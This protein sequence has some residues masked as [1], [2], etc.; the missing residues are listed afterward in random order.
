MAQLLFEAR[1][2]IV[3]QLQTII[4]NPRAFFSVLPPTTN[5]SQSTL[6]NYILTTMLPH[7]HK[8]YVLLDSCLPTLCTTLNW[9]LRIASLQL[10]S[11]LL[12]LILS[13]SKNAGIGCADIKLTRLHFM[14]YAII[15]F[16]SSLIIYY[17]GEL[18]SFEHNNSSIYMIT[19]FPKS[20]LQNNIFSE[21]DLILSIEELSPRYST[22]QLLR[23]LSG[24]FIYLSHNWP[25][26]SY[27]QSG[28]M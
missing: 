7:N 11:V 12:T 9:H 15:D 24:D 21:H 13:A 1:V 23:Q 25:G 27:C 16:C 22:R 26:R 4:S 19:L 14:L 5:H 28:S 8:I 2:D 6:V 3:V 17:C 18:M 10:H 20:D